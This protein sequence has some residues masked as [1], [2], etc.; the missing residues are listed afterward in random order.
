[1]TF[2]I[3]FLIGFLLLS[4]P[5]FRQDFFVEHR[6]IFLFYFFLFPIGFIIVLWS[7][8]GKRLIRLGILLSAFIF[9]EAALVGSVVY[10]AYFQS[11]LLLPDSYF[12]WVR[13]QYGYFK[14]TTNFD[15]D[16]SCYDSLLTYRF[17]P[18]ITGRFSNPEFDVEVKSNSLGVRDDET[19]LQDPAIV[20]LGDSHAMGWGV[21]KQ[22]RF[23]E[24]IEKRL[25]T[26]V[27]NTAI[28]SYGTHRETKLLN[29]V[30]LDSC[31]LLIIQYCENDLLEN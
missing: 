29:Q 7:F 17:R 19:S 15:S 24:I 27:L 1:M 10:M 2:A 22:E 25:N 23:S 14:G 3:R 12:L 5:L 13:G 30:D 6:S 31:R 21:E 26:N 28:T 20:V 8:A 9:I 18:N 4:L 16:L 11:N